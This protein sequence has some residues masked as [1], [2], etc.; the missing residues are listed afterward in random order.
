MRYFTS[1]IFAL[2][3]FA[4]CANSQTQQKGTVEHVDA[5]KFK[6]LV[7]TKKGI[8]LDVRTPK[9]FAAGYI[10]GADNID[11]YEDNFESEIGKL[12]KSK[13]VYVY[14]HAGGRSSDA[15]TMLQQKGFKVFNLEDGFS[16]WKQKGYPISK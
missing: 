15:A 6:Q 9:E 1:I 2:F 7:E 3:I 13:E 11:I 4:G 8:I 10:P 5:P 16:D 12:D 14:C